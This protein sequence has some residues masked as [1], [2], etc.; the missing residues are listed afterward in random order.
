MS[1]P[2]AEHPTW[3][4]TV[5]ELFSAPYWVPE[6]RREAVGAQWHRCMSSLLDSYE[7]VRDAAVTVYEH[8]ASRSMPLVTDPEQFW[9]P[10]AIAL[11]RAWIEEGCRRS[12]EDP[13]VRGPA[14]PPAGLTPLL[15]VRR[16]ILDLSQEELDEYR[17]RLEDLGA[18]SLAPDAR[19]Q[20]IGSLHSNWCLHYQEAFLPW[21]RANLLWF[22]QQIGMA[23]PYWNFMSPDAINDGAPA[24]GLLAPFREL[25]YRSPRTGEVRANPLRFAVAF[26][27]RSKAC[28]GRD[29]PGVD[30]R[31]VQRFPW[32]YTSG[33]EDREQRLQW[34]ALLGTFQ[35]QIDFA[36]GWPV[37]ST[38]EGVPG[39]PWADIPTFHPPQPDR[40]YPHRTDFDGLYEQPHDNLHGWIGPDMADNNY[41]AFDPVF[42]SLHSG[43][44]M[45][46]E[47][48]LRAHPASQYSSNFPLRPFT[49]PRAEEL[50]LR[51]PSPFVYT[52]LGDMAK[53]SRCLGYDY[54]PTGEAQAK[55]APL[56][57]GRPRA[58]AAG[59]D[60][61]TAAT[62]RAPAGAHLYI[63]FPDTRCILE[64]YTI[65]VFLNLPEPAPE[66]MRDGAADHFVGR[67][68]RLGMGIKDDKGRCSSTGVTRVLDATHTA[69]QLAL[70]PESA[71]TVNLIVT[72]HH[73]GRIVPQAEHRELPGFEPVLRWGGP[74]P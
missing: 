49:G 25:T 73:S 16:N 43:I 57:A 52:T 58:A 44:D 35:R 15:R 62:A 30:C 39:M 27:A 54:G 34:L 67:I 61:D 3:D 68:T 50:D 60:D 21:H 6:P 64:T 14:L 38:P 33:D 74:M 4:D 22:E 8:L 40:L 11:L 17:Q 63:L 13:I 26:E 51:S 19:W 48:W 37:F 24:A 45:I 2:S 71:I 36:L 9:P 23:I 12:A 7:H 65:D 55:G 46:F 5:G 1:A 72:H 47:R 70:T 59:A 28:T 18:T 29:A 53:D 41:T 66:H 42:W 56:A 20:R 31:Y 69:G 10:D 32:L